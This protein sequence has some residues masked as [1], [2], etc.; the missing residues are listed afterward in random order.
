[1]LVAGGSAAVSD[2]AL[3]DLAALGITA[4]RVSGDT[5]FHTAAAIA[6]LRGAA[7]ASAADS[8]ILIGGTHANAWAD[9]FPAALLASRTLTPI[10]LADHDALP[11][12]TA[13]YLTNGGHPLICGAAATPTAC[14]AAEATLSR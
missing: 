10:V 13:S 14:D 12:P 4:T 9:A 1:M 7:T 11:E 8:S 2:Q 5:R 6:A 3:S